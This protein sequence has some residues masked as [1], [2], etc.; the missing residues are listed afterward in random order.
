MVDRNSRPSHRTSLVGK[1]LIHARPFDGR[2]HPHSRMHP[3]VSEQSLSARP[4]V[5][6]DPSD[7][8]AVALCTPACACRG[9]IAAAVG[10]IA[11]RS[12]A[13][14]SPVCMR[15]RGPSIVDC[16]RTLACTVRFSTNRTLH[17]RQCLSMVARSFRQSHPA[18]SVVPV[19][20]RTSVPSH[21]ARRQATRRSACAGHALRSSIAYTYSHALYDVRPLALSTHGCSARWSLSAS[22]SRT[23]YARHCQ[24][25]IEDSTRLPHRMSLVA[26][27][28][29]GLHAHA[30]PFDRRLTG[31]RE[32]LVS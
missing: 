4:A 30:L 3:A 20:D 15:M 2:L 29:A 16:L 14:N 18:S 22:S 1:A 23:L 31:G 32:K 13:G 11:R 5:L 27:Q 8:P 21:V 12:S 7:P 26:R 17:A 10:R 24:S 25:R 19:E 6:D 9:S 28:H